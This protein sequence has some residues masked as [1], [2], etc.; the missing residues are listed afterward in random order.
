LL[1]PD[2]YEGLVRESYGKEL[3]RKALRLNA[4]IPRM[5]RR[6]EQAFAEMGLEFHKTRPAR[7]L[8]AKMAQ[9]PEKIMTPSAADRFARLFERIG[10]AHA[11]KLAREPAPFR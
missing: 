3:G 2:V 5:V 8:L 11:K 7:L 10:E 6:Y 4:M 9:E 1:D